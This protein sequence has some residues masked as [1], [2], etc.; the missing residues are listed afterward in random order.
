VSLSVSSFEN[1]QG[2][3]D[4]FPSLSDTNGTGHVTLRR[5]GDEFLVEVENILTSI[6]SSGIF[7]PGQN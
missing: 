1:G 7:I 2:N 6:V 4:G 5:Y 3:L